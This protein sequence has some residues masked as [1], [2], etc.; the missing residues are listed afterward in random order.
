MQQSPA[1]RQRNCLS[2]YLSVYT[3][4]YTQEK[5][6]LKKIETTHELKELY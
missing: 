2:V 3:E 6:K 1:L 4:Y 5:Q